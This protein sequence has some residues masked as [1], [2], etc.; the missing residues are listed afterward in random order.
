M[1]ALAWWPAASAPP[2]AEVSG[3]SV[4]RGG[5][6]LLDRIDW[7]VREGEHW[8]VLGSNGA[9][10]TTLVQVLA[11]SVC[12]A[13]GQLRLFGESLDEAEPA[14]LLAR[15][16]WTS[17]ALA[18]RLPFAERALDVVLTASYG[19]VARG[20][21]DYDEVDEHR[22]TSLLAQLGCRGLSHRPFGSL[23]EGERK[24]V[25]IAR[26]LMSDPELLLLDE[27]G[28][29]LDLGGREA[30]LRRLAR[31]AADATSPTIVLVTHHVEDVPPGFTHALLLRA[32]RVVTA[33]PIE[34]VLTGSWLSACFGL[35]L[36]VHR[37]GDRFT[38][39]AA[40]PHG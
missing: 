10:K 1:T 18:D 30:L 8:V 7:T 5:A 39:R 26:S 27:P 15:V 2:V 9:G 19:R 35:P 20:G 37:F 16:G 4:V 32:G 38:A 21:E 17:A 24:R 34:E 22:A 33:G 31:L 3:V 12:P 11:G 23:S 14:D 13:T 29:G 40:L 25:Q 28:A 6:V 36:L